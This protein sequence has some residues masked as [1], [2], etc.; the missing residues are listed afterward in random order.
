MKKIV[1]AGVGGLI[2]KPLIEHLR[3]NYEVVRLDRNSRERWA[4]EVEG[5]YAVI[6]LAGEPIAGKRWTSAQKKEGNRSGSPLSKLRC[7]TPA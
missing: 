3:Q 5:A 6:N 1:A 2:G 4:A 7:G